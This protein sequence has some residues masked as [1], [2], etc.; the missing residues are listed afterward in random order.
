MRDGEVGQADIAERGEPVADDDGRA[1]EQQPVDEAGAQ[2]GG[3][4]GGAALDQQVVDVGQGGDGFRA[5]DT[6]PPFV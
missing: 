1:V 4:G 5:I 3:G 6:L 2:E